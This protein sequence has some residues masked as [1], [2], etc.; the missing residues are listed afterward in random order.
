MAYYRACSCPLSWCHSSLHRRAHRQL[1]HH[2]S[3]ASLASLVDR[4][5]DQLMRITAGRPFVLCTR[6]TPVCAATVAAA[7]Q[8]RAHVVLAPNGS[9]AVL[10]AARCH[11]G[12]SR[13]I[14]H[15]PDG[16]VHVLHDNAISDDQSRVPEWMAHVALG[17]E[18]AGACV[19]ATSGSGQL[20]PKLVAYRWDACEQQARETVTRTLR[21][22][23]PR[24]GR[25]RF[26]AA[27]NIGHAYNLN[28]MFAA[29]RS[30]DTEL[31]VPA[32]A[33]E[34]AATL[35]HPTDAEATIVF[36]TPA[37]YTALC[38]G[39]RSGHL[40]DV[41]HGRLCAF[42]A[43]CMLPLRSKAAV[44]DA[45]GVRVLQNYGSSETGNMALE[46]I[47]VEIGADEHRACRRAREGGVADR[48]VPHAAED[49]GLGQDV[50]VPW[51]ELQLLPPRGGVLLPAGAEGEVVMR[52]P[53]ASEGYVASGRL[54]PHSTAP[55]VSTGDAGRLGGTSV[56][57][58]RT[59]V[60]T[61]RLRPPIEVRRGGLR[62]LLQGYEVERE[63]L[64]ANPGATAA[65][66]LQGPSGTLLCAL[67]STEPRPRVACLDGDVQPDQCL[68]LDELP[69]SPAGKVLYSQ[70]QSRFDVDWHEG[71]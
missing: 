53:W 65:A 27:S 50:G 37:I 44:A 30:G 69:S 47:D 29:L 14:D 32:N 12:V 17:G 54:L 8:L 70:L 16:M 48:A 10:A 51:G 20:G 19:V 39:L 21:K 58:G 23:T 49:D 40:R 38:A 18:Q 71:A 34:L 4:Q 52:L 13:V 7:A 42:S 66:A 56:G 5:R 61:G 24:G 3:A 60:L 25:L 6:N 9:P 41:L 1:H 22:A 26:V 15:S 33:A 59:L 43:G 45:L 64:R 28:G 11:A 63:L 55:Y 36:G 67:A 62:I 46:E 57:G 35:A 68:V 31:C 2:V